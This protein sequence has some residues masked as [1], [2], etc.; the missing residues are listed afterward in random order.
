MEK[1]PKQ[2]TNLFVTFVDL[3]IAFD[4]AT[5]GGGGTVANNS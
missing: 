4:A 5:G 1:S 3:E 2:R